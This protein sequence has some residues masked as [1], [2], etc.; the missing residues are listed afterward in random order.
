MDSGKQEQR[1]QKP[2]R[3]GENK[4]SKYPRKY[5]QLKMSFIV[6]VRTLNASGVRVCVCHHNRTRHSALSSTSFAVVLW[7]YYVTVIFLLLSTLF[8]SL[9]CSAPYSLGPHSIASF[10]RI[11]QYTIYNNSDAIAF[12]L[13]ML[14]LTLTHRIHIQYTFTLHARVP[15]HQAATAHDFDFDIIFPPQ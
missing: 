8:L 9:S 15:Y 7:V 4:G 3:I 10:I 6:I 5:P 12:Y 2:R 13:W 11:I 1:S 14:R